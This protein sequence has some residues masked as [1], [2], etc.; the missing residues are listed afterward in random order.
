M[1][2]FLKVQAPP[3]STPPDTPLPQ[4]NLFRTASLQGFLA[5]ARFAFLDHC[6]KPD[7]CKG[8]VLFPGVEKTGTATTAVLEA[9]LPDALAALPWPKSMR[10]G[11]N[12]LRWVRPLHS[13]P[14]VFEGQVVPFKFGHLT[15]GDETCGH[16]FM[17][18]ARFAVPDSAESPL[19]PPPPRPS[20]SS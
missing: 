17:A 3:Q 18:P 8:G 19:P 11:S 5:S 16:R 9:I 6:R 13:I 1:F 12:A 4:Q 10:W 7:T 20:T 2:R 14:R 15:A